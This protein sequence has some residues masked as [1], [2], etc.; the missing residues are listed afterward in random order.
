M[1][2]SKNI[3][4]K[5]K[6]C[7]LENLS[8]IIKHAYLRSIPVDKLLSVMKKHMNLKNNNNNYD[9]DDYT[10]IVTTD[11]HSLFANLHKN[12]ATHVPLY[13][14]SHFGN[15]RDDENGMNCE[16]DALLR[17]TLQPAENDSFAID[18][19][20]CCGKST[21]VAKYPNAKINNYLN[22]HAHNYNFQATTALEYLIL[23][24]R[25]MTESKNIVCDRSPISN[26]AFQLTY[27]LMNKYGSGGGDESLNGLC[28]KYVRMHNMLPALE[29]LKGLKLN[30]I[31][32]IDSDIDDIQRRMHARD[33]SA[34][35]KIKSAF[36]QYYYQNAAF[37]YLANRLAL[38]CFDLN[39]FARRYDVAD[40]ALVF[41]RVQ[42]KVCD[43][44][45]GHLTADEIVY[46]PVERHHY[47]IPNFEKLFMTVM[48][49]S[50]R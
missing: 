32:I 24:I 25:M 21:I 37:A 22:D 41:S 10:N 48:I 12:G 34:S 16:M 30:I 23:S 14:I 33:D 31:I 29:F 8:K 2:R 43:F 35:D 7:K 17:D 9:N 50:N 38:P 49:L 18:G 39:Y 19:T 4:S 47:N 13:N 44:L 42:Q 40:K 46:P 45:N 1:N 28:E 5:Y 3:I 6:N 15:G 20:T 26:I 11:W 27:Y 36:P